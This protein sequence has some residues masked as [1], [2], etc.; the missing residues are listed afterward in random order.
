MLL[1]GLIGLTRSVRLN[2]LVTL[3]KLSLEALSIR[4]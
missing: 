4:Q 1:V 3:L 2:L